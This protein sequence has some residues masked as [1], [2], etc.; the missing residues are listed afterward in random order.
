MC[1][2]LVVQ[3]CRTVC[4][5]INCNPAGSSVHGIL[6]LSLIISLLFDTKMDDHAK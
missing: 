2:L 5:L 1:A 3:L 6:Y 4:N